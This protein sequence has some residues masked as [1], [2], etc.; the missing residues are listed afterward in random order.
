MEIFFIGNISFLQ[1][2]HA[3]QGRFVYAIETVRCAFKRLTVAE[4][5]WRGR[6]TAKVRALPSQD[7]RLPKSGFFG[8]GQEQ[9]APTPLPQPIRSRCVTI[10]PDPT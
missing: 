5:F 2:G 10:R 6:T 3:R 8:S 1:I 4:G 9:A 7:R